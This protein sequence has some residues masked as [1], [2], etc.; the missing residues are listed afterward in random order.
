MGLS[1]T[2][3]YRLGFKGVDK[4]LLEYDSEEE[5]AVWIS[6]SSSSVSHKRTTPWQSTWEAASG[7]LEERGWWLFGSERRRVGQ[8]LFVF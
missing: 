6:L 7:E 3:G 2:R 8:L 4:E 1:L 5:D